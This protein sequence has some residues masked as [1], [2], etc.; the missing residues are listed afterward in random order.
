MHSC[1]SYSSAVKLFDKSNCMLRA[2]LTQTVKYQSSEA[3]A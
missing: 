1:G 3:T 2:M